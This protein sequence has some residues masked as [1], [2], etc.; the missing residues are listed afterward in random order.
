MLSTTA[1]NHEQAL[2]LSDSDLEKLAQ[3][4]EQLESI[5]QNAPNGVNLDFELQRIDEIV[6]AVELSQKTI[7]STQQVIQLF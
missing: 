6:S 5:I 1:L 4:L 3:E 2:I 7:C